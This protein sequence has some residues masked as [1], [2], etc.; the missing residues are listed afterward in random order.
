[1]TTLI[2]KFD[3]KNGGATPANTLN[4]AINLKLA[5]TVA[6]TDFD[7]ANASAKIIA[8][9]ASLPSTGGVVD[10]TMLQ[11]TQT[12]SSTIVIGS[13]TRPVT[14]LL[15]HGAKFQPSSAS[16]QMFSVKANGQLIGATI[17]TTNVTYSSTAVLFDDSTGDGNSSLIQDLIINGTVDEGTGLQISTS[18]T[19][20]YGIAF[21]T[22]N[23]IRIVGY[24]V[25]VNIYTNNVAQFINGNSFNNIEVKG[26]HIGFNFAGTGNI[27]ANQFMS[28][29][30]QAGATSVVG[31]NITKGEYN[32]FLNTNI[33]DMPVGGDE[34]VFAAGTIN[35]N[36]SGY[37]DS[38]NAT[39][40]GVNTIV[41]IQ[42]IFPVLKEIQ[43]FVTPDVT[44]GLNFAPSLTQSPNLIT[45]L[46]GG[47]YELSQGS[48][49]VVL[50]SNTTGNIA[51]FLCAA[52]ATTLIS[53]PSSSYSVT[54]GTASRI[55]FAYNGGTSKYRIQNASG[56]TQ[57]IYIS[58][59]KTRY[60]N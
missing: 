2:P 7:G 47:T 53:D 29:T 14:L 17:N 30:Y 18:G 20:T 42:N 3:F 59:I 45:M 1:M 49:I 39:N 32:T 48:G 37:V 24:Y 52:N 23:Q 51:M 33:W 31:F 12:I 38:N 25:G 15:S 43:S 56:S 50:H 35:N 21:L 57:A 13:S 54:L 28:C 5:D 11:G 40:N 41:G 60:S 22:I 4:R 9:I 36:M 34:Y 26:S 19:S 10:G 27:N 8:A 58:L 44:W 55:N 16:I 6:V 46:N